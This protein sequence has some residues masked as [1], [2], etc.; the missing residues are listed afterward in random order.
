MSH[1]R[2]R[3]GRWHLTA[4]ALCSH[5]MRGQDGSR[6]PCPA[7]SSSACSNP[8]SRSSMCR[9]PNLGLARDSARG[10]ARDLARDSARGCPHSLEPARSSRSCRCTVRSWTQT[11]GTSQCRHRRSHR[12]PPRN[13]SSHRPAKGS[14]K[15]SAV[16]E[17]ALG[18]T[19]CTRCHRR[20]L[21]TRPHSS[22]TRRPGW[23]HSWDRHTQTA[24]STGRCSRGHSDASSTADA[25]PGPRT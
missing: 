9:A 5:R 20:G 8:S 4:S 25:R 18:W 7:R 17:S 10:S 19:R 3:R 14:A 23:P 15:G 11:G 6:G 2:R 12:N 21:C 1:R 16:S 22:C 24:S 13:C